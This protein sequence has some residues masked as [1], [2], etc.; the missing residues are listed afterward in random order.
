MSREFS[1]LA[2]RPPDALVILAAGRGSRYGGSKQTAAV[3]PAGE[4][5]LDYA[6]HDARRAGFDDVVLVIAPGQAGEFVPVA[7]RW[8]GRM[9]VR[10]V[11]Q[12]LDDLPAGFTR[13]LRDKP[14][15]TAHAV[16]SARHAVAGPFAV[17]NAD[18]FYGRRAYELARDAI[19]DARARDEA[20]IVGFPLAITRSPHGAVKRA[21]CETRAGLVTRVTETTVPAAGEPAPGIADDAIVSMNFW[22]FPPRVMAD[23]ERALGAFLG[24]DGAS[25]SAELLLPSVVNDLVAAGTLPVRLREAPGPWM[26]L[27]YQADRAATVDALRRLTDAGTYFAPVWAATLDD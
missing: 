24:R 21:I 10:L 19:D 15:G 25:P 13:G 9:P 2:P 8:R 18:D 23:V 7:A 20:T 22:V 17:V 27:T 16:W 12:R 3:G 4:W 11:E 5:L 14:W 1:I 6:I 26:G